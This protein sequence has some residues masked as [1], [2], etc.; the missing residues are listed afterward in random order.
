MSYAITFTFEDLPLIRAPGF[1]AGLLDGLAV[2]SPDDDGWH[3]SGIELRDGTGWI[4]LARTEPAF[5]AIAVAVE[6]DHASDIERL[7]VAA[8]GKGSP[9]LSDERLSAMQLG[10]GKH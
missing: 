10:V 8:T 3:I 2:I 4:E 1:T 5:N 6:R 9:R 7:V